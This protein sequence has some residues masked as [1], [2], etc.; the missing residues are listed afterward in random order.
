[1]IIG[2]STG[3]FT[4]LHVAIS[5]VAILAGVVVVAAMIAGT[6]SRAW[7]ALFLAT[8]I[9]TSVTGFMFHSQS[10]GPP[11]IIGAI[12]LVILALAVYAL[13]VRH[14][15]GYWRPV[16]IVSAVAALYL[17]VFVGVVQ[18]FQKI[19]LLQALAP[20]QTEMP[21]LEAQIAVLVIVAA[22]GLLALRRFRPGGTLAR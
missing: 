1:M 7:T 8:T 2:L 13:Y 17:N 22:F 21:F 9:A 10:F 3:S 15:A 19:P 4:L 18:A 16:Y 12:S 14:L 20:T 6:R 5:L 11:H